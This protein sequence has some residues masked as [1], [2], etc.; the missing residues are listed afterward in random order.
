VRVIVFGAGAVGGVIGAKLFQ[1]EHD[2]T[3]IARGAN[4]AALHKNGILLET[5]VESARLKVPVVEQ[6][7]DLTFGR[8]D[9]VILT[10]K[11]QDTAAALGSLSSVAPAATAVVCGQNG[12]ENE[13][14]ALRHFRDVYGM[15]VMLPATHLTPGV[16]QVYSSPVCGLLDVGR[17]PQGSDSRI[18]ELAD[19]LTHSSFESVVRDDIARW[20]WGKLMMNLGNAVEAVCGPMARPGILWQRAVDEG[21]AVLAAAG[22]DYV[23]EEE[24]SNRR[25][26]LMNYN[27]I[28]GVERGGGSSWQSLTRSTGSIE[29]DYLTGEIVL[30]GRLH[31]VATPV[32]E[33][34]QRL[35]NLLA[36]QRR[37]PGAWSENDVVSMLHDA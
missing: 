25:G 1:H 21:K 6:P 15:C 36:A 30:Q 3:F 18:A 24:D 10:V 12:V 5:P 2:V 33:L 20:K 32:N 22:I 19:V 31:G 29:T 13:R 4:F 37:A 9:V 35:A 16:V 34:L 28:N 17:W 23:Q 8:E 27:P 11:S 14:A 26:Q 7:S